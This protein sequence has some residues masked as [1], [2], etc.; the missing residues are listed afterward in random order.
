MTASVILNPTEPN[1]LQEGTSYR[2][3]EKIFTNFTGRGQTSVCAIEHV[4]LA[5]HLF[6]NFRPLCCIN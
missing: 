2:A 1:I 6:I 3:E 5:F 4:M